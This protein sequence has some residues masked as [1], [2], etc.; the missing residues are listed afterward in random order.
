MIAGITSVYDKNTVILAGL[1]TAL[2][3]VA[4]TF[5]AMITKVNIQ[6]FHGF[7]WVVSFAVLPMIIVGDVF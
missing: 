1:G 4:L 7:V 3:T 5:Y 2:V 6:V